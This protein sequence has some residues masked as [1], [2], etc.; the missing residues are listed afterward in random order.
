VCLVERRVGCELPCLFDA[1]HHRACL[2]GLRPDEVIGRIEAF[3]ANLP[4]RSG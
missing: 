3:L 1:C 2:E 4:A